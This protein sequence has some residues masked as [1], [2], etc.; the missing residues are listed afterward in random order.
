[1]EKPCPL[2][3]KMGPNWGPT[4]RHK[5]IKSEPNFIKRGP[6]RCYWRSVESL[7][8]PKGALGPFWTDFGM[9]TLLSTAPEPPARSETLLFTA[10]EP[11]WP[12]QTLLLTAPE[13]LWP[14]EPLLLLIIT[15]PSHC[16]KMLVSVTLS[17]VLLSIALLCSVHGYARVHTSIYI[18]IYICV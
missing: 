16:S 6:G 10:P 18:Y 11:L 2:C 9:Q 13:P 12:L 4:K 8:C 7:R 5:S 14:F 1:M 17:S 15:A 3:W